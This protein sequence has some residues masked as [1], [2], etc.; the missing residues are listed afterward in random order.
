MF[1]FAL[2]DFG[3]NMVDTIKR[4]DALC[5]PDACCDYAFHIGVKD[6]SGGLLDSMAE[7]ADYGVTSFKVFMVYDFGVT[8]GV[9]FKVLQKSKDI[10]A[11]IGVHAENN[12]MVNM[13]TEKYISEGKTSAW[14]HYLSRPEWVE[15]EAD[16]R[17]IDWAKAA[18]AEL[19]IVHLANKQGMEAVQK[20][21]E[22]PVL[23]AGIQALGHTGRS[24]AAS[25][26]N[27]II[28]HNTD[29]AVVAAAREAIRALR[30]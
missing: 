21:T 13:L 8:D 14:Y 23:L 28:E 3:E 1:D 11:L 18:G 24:A 6:V 5:A 12:E 19:Y 27:Y 7:A 4:R 17:A 2:Q 20:A 29:D 25:Q 22:Q 10:G 9:F 26:L 15:G 30:Q 16:E